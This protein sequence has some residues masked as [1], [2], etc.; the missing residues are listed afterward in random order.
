MKNDS[1]K[2]KIGVFQSI[3][4]IIFSEREYFQ[5]KIY[6]L[7]LKI[8]VFILEKIL[9][10]F[11]FSSYRQKIDLSCKSQKITI[12]KMSTKTNLNLFVLKL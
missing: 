10:P 7:L 3:F 8:K 5:K 12:K 11:D 6:D 9:F 1:L 2:M 4:L